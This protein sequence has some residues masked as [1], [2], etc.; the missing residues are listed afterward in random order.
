MLLKLG[1]SVAVLSLFLMPAVSFAGDAT[2]FSGGLSNATTNLASVKAGAGTNYGNADLPTLIG[3]FVSIILGV[4]GIILVVYI[5]MAGVAYMTAAG[6]DK[7]IQ[8][9]KDNI[10]NAIIGMFI[11]LAAYSIS[12][13]VISLLVTAGA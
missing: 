13:F 9:A 4:M 3:R 11:I 8:K 1:A 6:D 5:I 10:K 7:K 2:G 12:T